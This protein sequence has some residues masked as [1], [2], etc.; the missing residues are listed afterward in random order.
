MNSRRRHSLS[1]T[2]IL[3]PAKIQNKKKEPKNEIQKLS[4]LNTNQKQLSR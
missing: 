4:G 1:P 3:V 2:V